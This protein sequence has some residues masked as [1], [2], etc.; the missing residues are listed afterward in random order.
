MASKKKRFEV[1]RLE[2]IEKERSTCGYRQ[3]LFSTGDDTKAYFHVVRINDSK[4]HYHKRATEYYYVLEGEGEMTVDGETFP[5]GPGTMVKLDPL[6]VHR[7]YGDHLVLVCGVPDIEE[8]DI[9][10]SEEKE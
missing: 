3:R 5:I 8:D 2:T 4:L 10:F 1:K 6:S 9:F 7:S